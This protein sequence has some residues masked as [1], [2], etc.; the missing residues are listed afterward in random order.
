[1]AAP[2]ELR[3]FDRRGLDE[4]GWRRECANADRRLSG[5]SEL[6]DHSGRRSE[7]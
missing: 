3:V 5:H 7:R 1:M 2:N 6:G 4:R